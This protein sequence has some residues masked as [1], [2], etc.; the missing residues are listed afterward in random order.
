[1]KNNMVSFL[2]ENG[3]PATL[4]IET[5][6]FV[7][8]TKNFKGYHSVIRDENGN[9]LSQFCHTDLRARIHWANGYFTALRSNIIWDLKDSLN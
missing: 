4:H 1:M 2:K 5:Q 8:V 9:I 7:V 6:D 3:F